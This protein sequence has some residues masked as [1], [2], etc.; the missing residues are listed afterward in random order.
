LDTNYEGWAIERGPA[1]AELM[2]KNDDGQQEEGAPE[3]VR[4][5]VLIG[6]LDML[7]DDF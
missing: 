4:S 5:R 3:P 1:T 7:M 2:D 6:Q